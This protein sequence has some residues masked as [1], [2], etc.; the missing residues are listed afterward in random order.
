MPMKNPLITFY[1]TKTRSKDLFTPLTEGVVKIYSCGPTVYHYA[2][3]G[4]LRAYVFADILQRT[5]RAHNYKVEHVINITDVG[6]LVGD[7]DAGMDKLEKGAA[8]EG[9]TAWEIASFYTD[10]FMNDLAYLNIPKENYSFPK[11]TD[12]IPEQ[13]ALIQTL[14]Q[15]GYTYKISD[16]IYFDTSK[17]LNYATFAKLNLEGLAHGARVT[18]NEEKKTATDFALWKF[19]NQEEKRHMEWESP[20]GK[21]FPGWHIECSAM[22]MKYLGETF[23]IHTGGIDHIPVHHTNEIAQS[24]CATG[25]PYVNYWMH[26]NFLNDTEGKMSKSNDDFLTLSSLIKDGYDPLAYRYFLLTVHYRK[27]VSFSYEALDGASIAYKKLKEFVKEHK[28]DGGEIIELYKEEVLEALRNDLSTAEVIGTIWKM[29]RDTTIDDKDKVATI[30]YVD[31][32]LGL[33]LSHQE[34][35]QI[36]EEVEILLAQRKN[37]KENKDY[38][39]CDQLREKIHTLGF[40]VKDTKNGQEIEQ[41]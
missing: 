40:T 15:K 34:K 35:L 21:G 31:T 38:L 25:H 12:H 28:K 36:P 17:Y 32:I 13:I 23:D 2:H 16:G 9:K 30:L 37:A 24:V 39:T 8:R 41:L 22:S 20:W 29:I 18:E 19:S 1:N 6:H 11:A 3:I 4:N 5:L 7:G 26:V 10:A 14:E 27:E 33:K